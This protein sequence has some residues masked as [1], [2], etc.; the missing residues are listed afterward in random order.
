MRILFLGDIVGH[1]GRDCL[2]HLLRDL[3]REKNISY[4]VANG[5]NAAGGSGITQRCAQDLYEAGVDAITMGDHL[6]KQKDV[7]HLLE[8]DPH[9]FRPLN[10]PSGTPG[11]GFGCITKDSLPPLGIINMQGRTFMAPLENPFNAIESAVDCLR[12]KTNL[13]LVDFHAEATS[14]KIAMGWLLD[15]KVSLVVGTH[16]HVQTSDCRIL[17]RGTG[18]LTDAGFCGPH[19]SVIGREIEP[20]IA[21][22]KS[23]RPNRFPVA[24]GD[25]RMQGVLVEVEE[26]SGQARSIELISR[27]LDAMS[28]SMLSDS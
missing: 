6:W 9:F 7:I 1:K 19:E 20:V 4:V 15:G 18:Y 22:F 28:G 11:H 13:I 16:T 25:V 3:M 23:M 24:T 10:Y 12:E 2:K 26:S 5:E 8:N 14:E 27:N 17:P 21:G